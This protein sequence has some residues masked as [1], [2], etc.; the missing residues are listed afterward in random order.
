MLFQAFTIGVHFLA[1]L[2]L[3]RLGPVREVSIALFKVD[4][5]MVLELDLLVEPLEAD[6]TH[7]ELEIGMGLTMFLE[8]RNGHSLVAVT[9]DALVHIAVLVVHLEQVAGQVRPLGVRFVST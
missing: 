9:L 3:F 8:G 7:V 2:A 4:H 6:V 1:Y 5:R